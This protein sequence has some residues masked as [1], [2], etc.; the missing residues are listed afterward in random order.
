M[1][2]YLPRLNIGWIVSFASPSQDRLLWFWAILQYRQT[3][4]IYLT[5]NGTHMYHISIKRQIIR[6]SNDMNNV[7]MD[8]EIL[9][10]IS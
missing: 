1:H 3:T 2:H 4:V 5:S 7:R 6:L 10:K 8:K 9:L